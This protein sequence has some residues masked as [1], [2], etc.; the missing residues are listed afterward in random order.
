MNSSQD[1]TRVANYSL[2]SYTHHKNTMR[3]NVLN[4]KIDSVIIPPINYVSVCN[5]DVYTHSIF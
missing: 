2:A 1:H 4:V 5:D 3:I